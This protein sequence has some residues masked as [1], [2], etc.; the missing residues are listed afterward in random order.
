MERQELSTLVDKIHYTDDR[1]YKDFK[2]KLM[3]DLDK[4][5]NQE[6]SLKIDVIKLG[7]GILQ[8]MVSNPEYNKTI[9]LNSEMMAISARDFTINTYKKL[10]EL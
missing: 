5:I 3:S 2:D 8:G 6:I 4:H 10:L 1:L 7:M 9:G